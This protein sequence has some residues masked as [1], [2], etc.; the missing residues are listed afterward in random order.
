MLSN[1]WQF[2][3]SLYCERPNW[4]VLSEFELNIPNQPD[5]S[6]RI[7]LASSVLPRLLAFQIPKENHLLELIKPFRHP[8]KS[9]S[10]SHKEATRNTV[11]P[12]EQPHFLLWIG[13]NMR[14]F[15]RR[16]S[17]PKW[18]FIFHPNISSS[19]LM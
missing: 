16:T 6:F 5:Q 4:P 15:F 12:K 9:S 11:L 2:H 8:K 18:V 3:L 13:Q 10:I 7:T 1:F 14:N 19:I 17:N